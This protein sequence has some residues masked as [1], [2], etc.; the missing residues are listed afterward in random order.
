MEEAKKRNL[1]TDVANVLIGLFLLLMIALFIFFPG[2][3]VV[4][5]LLF[6]A[7]GAMNLQTG[8]RYYREKGKRNS[9]MCFILLGFVILAVGVMVF[10]KM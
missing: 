6:L 5:A 4:L 9:G 1:L 10:I 7:A 2:N 3:A 8:F